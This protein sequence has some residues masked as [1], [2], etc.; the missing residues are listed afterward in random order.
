[1]NKVIIAL[2]VTLAVASAQDMCQL[3]L[4]SALPTL[5]PLYSNYKTRDWVALE[6]NV[7]T[8]IPTSQFIIQNCFDYS[9]LTSDTSQKCLKSIYS[10]ARLFAPLANQMNNSE[11]L[12]N[13][14]NNFGTVMGQSY[15]ACFF[16]PLYGTTQEDLELFANF[17]SA[18]IEDFQVNDIFSCISD[19]TR[20][21]PLFKTFIDDVKGKKGYD[22]VSADLKAIFA[23]I[24]PLCNDCGIPKPTGK[25][26]PIDIGACLVDADKLADDAYYVVTAKSDFIKI[27]SGITAFISDLPVAL[28][29]CGIIA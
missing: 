14:V 22:T 6:R 1:M 28:G 18:N 16:E 23:N 9:F 25:G 26:G 5:Q 2:F 17:D 29:H 10:V 27:I 15:S 13:L 21:I 12:V 11:A 24:S 8:I 19:V 4:F 20:M 7:E 3:S